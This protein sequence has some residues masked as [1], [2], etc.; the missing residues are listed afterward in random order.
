MTT[1]DRQP[2][3]STGPTSASGPDGPS[4]RRGSVVPLTG[5]RPTS[6]VRDAVQGTL[7]LDLVPALDPPPPAPQRTGPAVAGPGADVVRVDLR[8]RRRLESWAHRYVQAAVEIAGGDRPANQL[9]R[10]TAAPVHTDLARRGHLVARASVR[11]GGRSRDVVRPQVRSVHAGFVADDVAEISAHVR[12]GQRSRAVAARFELRA[13]RWI[14][15]AL[16]FA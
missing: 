4:T 10:W 7:A 1:T 9:L 5:R 13:E 8:R 15:T 11:G 6:P 16:E 3:P 12:Y 14:C 2:T